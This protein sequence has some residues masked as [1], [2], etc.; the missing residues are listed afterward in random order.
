VQYIQQ[1][2]GNQQ[3]PASD[4]NSEEEKL[5]ADEAESLTAIGSDKKIS[6]YM[7]EVTGRYLVAYVNL[8]KGQIQAKNNL[9]PLFEA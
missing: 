4:E 2:S 9:F 6:F 7:D 8:I 3:P 5:D 1:L